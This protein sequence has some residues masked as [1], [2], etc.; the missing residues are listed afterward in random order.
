MTK[1]PRARRKKRRHYHTGIFV[2][3][4][5]V[6]YKYRSGWEFQYMKYLDASTDVLSWTYESVV[7]PY[8]S[9][10]K[11]GKIRKY[12]PDFFIEWSDARREIIEIKPSKRV[13]QVKVQKKLKA[14]EEHCRAHGLTL[15]VI[16]EVELKG[17]GLL[18]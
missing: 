16:T 5:G 15:K 7:I 1:K 8:V 6:E 10:V 2:T 18:K 9:N 4:S 14:A 12:H 3:K 13:G 17:L 11:T